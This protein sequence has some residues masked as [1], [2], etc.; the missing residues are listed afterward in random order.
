MP[1]SRRSLSTVC[2]GARS[3]WLCPRCSSFAWCRANAHGTKYADILFRP[4]SEPNGDAV[5]TPLILFDGVCNLCNGWV[6]F[7][8]RHDPN[9]IFRFAAQ[10]TPTGQGIIRDYMSNASPLPSVILID[11]NAI[12][13]ESDAILQILGRLA[14]PW[15]WISLLR[16]IPRRVRDACYHFVARHRYQWFG[17]TDVCPVPS[18]DIRSRFIG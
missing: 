13:A 11:D 7:I 3:V 17:R 18:A 5:R 14:P 1:G 4:V 8:I 15:S 10:Q 16:I 2:L 12:Y 6:R 9:G